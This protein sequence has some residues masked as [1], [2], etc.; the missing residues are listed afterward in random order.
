VKGEL[1][2]RLP[3]AAA[4]SEG[5]VALVDDDAAVRRALQRLLGVMGFAVVSF[6]SAEE[7]LASRHRSDFR[8]LVS[9]VNLPGLSGIDLCS[10]LTAAGDPLPVILVSSDAGATSVM[11]RALGGAVCVLSKPLDAELLELALS[12]TRKG[13]SDKR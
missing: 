5:V 8:C 3:E 7:F 10:R 2:R 4:R 13:S 1:A 12:A 9:D 6:G 11:R